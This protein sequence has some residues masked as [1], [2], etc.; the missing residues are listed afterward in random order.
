[1]DNIDNITISKYINGELAGEELIQF[2][3]LLQQNK[4]LADEVYFHKIVD[5]TLEENYRTTSKIDESERLEFEGIL[6]KVIEKASIT[7]PSPIKK[8]LPLALAAAILLFLIPG[9]LLFLLSGSQ[10]GNSKLADEF[11]KPYTYLSEPT[12][13]SGNIEEGIKAY[14]A[15]D[16]ETALN[17]FENNS[18]GNLK[19][20]LAKGYTEYKLDKYNE[21]I[22]TFNSVLKKTGD[23]T[24]RNTANWYLALTYLKKDNKNQAI[25][26]LKQLPENAD[27]Y[28][29]AQTLLQKLE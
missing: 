11:D 19:L 13:N 18:S 22:N 5:E 29:Q 7:S 20:Q 12:L 23:T 27:F 14:Q 15:K 25:K 10:N 21:A 4:A 2:E 6:S 17:I 24:L 1:M 26:L 8:L 16:Y 28:K 3:S 9:S